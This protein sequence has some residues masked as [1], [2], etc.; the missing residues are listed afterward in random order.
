MIVDQILAQRQAI[1]SVAL[2]NLCAL[3]SFI[4]SLQLNTIHDMPASFQILQNSLLTNR[5]AIRRHIIWA[6]DSHRQKYTIL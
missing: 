1:L 2:C 4:Q 5:P 6:A 3:S